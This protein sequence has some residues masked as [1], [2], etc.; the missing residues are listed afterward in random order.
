MSIADGRKVALSIDLKIMHSIIEEHIAASP[1]VVGVE[2][3]RQIDRYVREQKL[4]YYPA[5][6]YFHGRNIVDSDLYNTAESIAWLLENLT[7][8]TLRT[9]LRP[10]L[11]DLLFDSTQVHIFILPHV[12]P[13]QNNAIHSLTTHLTPD[14]L[15]VSLKGM[16]KFNENDERSL[17]DKTVYEINNALD[18]FFSLHDISGIKLI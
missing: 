8:Q 6:D 17:I 9:H 11:S 2:L 10:L 1:Y 18:K 5:L 13:A 3:A 15:R 16:L 14:H 7:Q 12:R 4:G